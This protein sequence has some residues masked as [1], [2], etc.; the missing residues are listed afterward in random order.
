M[1][2]HKCSWVCSICGEGLTR[3][4]SATRHNRN[5]HSGKARIVRPLE[6]II[7]RVNR[8][9]P[10]PRDPLS[11]RHR[12]IN[13]NKN[14]SKGNS[15]AILSPY[16]HEGTND[17][18]DFR[19]KKFGS[20]ESLFSDRGLGT[21]PL[22]PT[23]DEDAS[24]QRYNATAEKDSPGHVL[25]RSLEISFKLKELKKLLNKHYPSELADQLFGRILFQL[26][27][28]NGEKF[29]EERLEWL[30]TVDKSA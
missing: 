25:R 29:L 13:N 3:R 24:Q 16:Y 12:T 23:Q 26:Q 22:I 28:V 15:S 30:N 20:G 11:Y 5:L 27:G 9:Y 7:G 17:D 4:T 2:S 18:S 21:A 14:K 1:M 6:Y 10:V 8:E 19:D